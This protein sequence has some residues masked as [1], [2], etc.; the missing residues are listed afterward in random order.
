MSIFDDISKQITDLKEIIFPT[1]VKSMLGEVV[2][3]LVVRKE[4]SKSN[5]ITDR[6]TESGFDLSDNAKARPM[7]INLTVL[8]N[9]KDYLINRDALRK[10]TDTHEIVSFIY[11]GRDTVDTVMVMDMSEIYDSE[12]AGGVTYDIV[13]KQM[14]NRAIIPTVTTEVKTL[15]GGKG[16]PGSATSTQVPPKE[17]KKARSSLASKILGIGG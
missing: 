11:A 6:R 7:I 13:L 15:P 8:D 1:P 9:S 5:A 14:R 12:F 10:L 17:E 4:Y 3:N 16:I 2:L